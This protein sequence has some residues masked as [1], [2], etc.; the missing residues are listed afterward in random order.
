[1]SPSIVLVTPETSAAI[2]SGGGRFMRCALAE[3][4]ASPGA[5]CKR[6]TRPPAARR[7]A[8]R[9]VGA[10]IHARRAVAAPSRR[11]RDG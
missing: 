9:A 4:R 5:S 11:R 8:R 6:R 7:G 1:L 2:W 3:V 10:A